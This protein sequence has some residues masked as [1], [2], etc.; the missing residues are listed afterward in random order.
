MPQSDA[1]VATAR[2]RAG[3]PLSLDSRPLGDDTV[4][5]TLQYHDFHYEQCLHPTLPTYTLEVL[6]LVQQGLDAYL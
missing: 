1:F 3:L 5:L 2:L 4:T 6:E